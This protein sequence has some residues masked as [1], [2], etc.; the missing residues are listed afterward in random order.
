M[1]LNEYCEALR[2]KRIAVIGYGISNK[3]LVRLLLR[4]GLDV[5]V[6]DK[7][8]CA[9][10]GAKTVCGD[11]YL[12]NLTEDVIFRTPALMPRTPELAAAVARGA[13]LTSETEAFFEV[14]PCRIIA[15]T[16]SDGKTTTSTLI[17]EMLRR[18]GYTVHL[19]GNIGTPLLD[20]ADEMKPTDF[21]VL[22]LS[23]FQLISMTRSADIAVI[24]NVT[25]NHLD[26]H[27]DFD[28]YVDA[29]R[30]VFAH[31]GENGI[32]VLN[33]DDEIC[34]KFAAEARGEVRFFN[35]QKI[36]FDIKIP[37]AHNVLNYKA[38][39]TAL[40][41]IVSAEAIRATAR[42]FG[43]VE[44]RNEFVRELRGVKFYNS[45]I[46]SSPT[47]TTAAIRSYGQKVIL[48]AGGKDK[49][50]AYD[51]IGLPIV[52]NVKTLVLTGM[53]ADKIRAAVENC[54][55]YH[56][57]PQIIFEPEFEAAVKTAAGVAASGDI[58]VLSPA[59]TSFDRFA[60]FEERGNYYKE[61]V[62]GLD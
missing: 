14:C 24:T 26:I 34:R 5:T 55:D 60:N 61:I 12:A 54:A 44:H 48:I 15:I 59:S 62:N 57:E 23:S 47:R 25:P 17:A 50:I 27:K 6:R 53:T 37:G 45:S 35:E 38:A 49:G 31:Q 20:R 29:K 41:D 7:K 4:Y 1:T 33:A 52:E 22:E 40:K 28:E 8:D 16:G 39:I 42:E 36:D 11:G 58:V 9:V 32:V 30:N 46:D 10:E 2:G 18:E 21:A 13:T 19:G 3:P 56:G 51:S 43:G